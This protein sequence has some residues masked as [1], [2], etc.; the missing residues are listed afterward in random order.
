MRRYLFGLTASLFLLAALP[1]T[2]LAQSHHHARHH[3]RNDR[4]EHFRRGRQVPSQPGAPQPAGRDAG[5][6]QS[7]QNGILMIKLNDGTI[8]SGA[9]TPGTEVECQARNQGDFSRADGS[10]DQSSG[11]DGSNDNGGSNGNGDDN[12]RGD[13][14]GGGDDNGAACMTALK[15]MGTPVLDATLKLTSAGAVWDRVDLDAQ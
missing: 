9:V 14:N 1:A 7:F 3:R 5:S 13:D 2:S 12:G 8:V 4:I 10:G 15:T 6:I 11:R